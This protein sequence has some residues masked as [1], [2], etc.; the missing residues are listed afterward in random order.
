MYKQTSYYDQQDIVNEARQASAKWIVIFHD[1]YRGNGKGYYQTVDNFEKSRV[2]RWIEAPDDRG[3]TNVYI[4]DEDV[5]AM[6]DEREKLVN[7]Y[8]K[9]LFERYK[10]DDIMM[11]K[12]DHRMKMTNPIRVEAESHNQH[13]RYILSQ[14][15]KRWLKKLANIREQL[16][17]TERISSTMIEIFI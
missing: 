12:I 1:H 15:E 4:T 7:K 5:P 2:F 8:H 6:V 13:M 16:K 17:S 10:T 9:V 3:A 14:R 11:L